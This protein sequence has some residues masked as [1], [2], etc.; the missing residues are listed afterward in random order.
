MSK[1][2]TYA[3]K[4]EALEALKASIARLTGEKANSDKPH[5][6]GSTLKP[7]LASLVKATGPEELK[8]L[9]AKGMESADRGLMYYSKGWGDGSERLMNT[10][11]YGRWGGENEISKRPFFD[12]SGDSVHLLELNESISHSDWLEVAISLEWNMLSELVYEL[13]S[14]RGQIASA[15]KIAAM[16]NEAK[17][18]KGPTMFSDK[19]YD[20]EPFFAMVRSKRASHRDAWVRDSASNYMRALKK[21]SGEFDRE[22]NKRVMSEFRDFFKSS[23]VSVF[24]IIADGDNGTAIIDDFDMLESNSNA[25]KQLFAKS[26]YEV[27]RKLRDLAK[28][29]PERL[30][31]IATKHFNS[32]HPNGVRRSQFM[33]AYRRLS[34]HLKLDPMG[35]NT[36]LQSYVLLEEIN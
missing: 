2:T 10:T 11:N 29:D 26:D 23:E 9:L 25:R 24:G 16:L 22:T 6:F 36:K 28:R 18:G 30:A 7:I 4:K 15:T 21:Y 19:L 31:K 13:L 8:S 27:S 33:R 20:Y 3:S 32:E 34:E 12:I 1:T 17:E 14:S 5:G 35:L